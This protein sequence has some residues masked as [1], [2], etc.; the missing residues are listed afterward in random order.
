MTE[1]NWSER[2]DQIEAALLKLSNLLAEIHMT[3]SGRM[4]EIQPLLERQQAQAGIG[5]QR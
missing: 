4:K 1:N 2:L 5:D 3:T